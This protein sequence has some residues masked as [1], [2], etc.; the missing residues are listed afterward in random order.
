MWRGPGK[1]KD[2]VKL[3]LAPKL[4]E[5]LVWVP[6]IL[7]CKIFVPSY[8]FDAL[9]CQN[10]LFS[11]P[12]RVTLPITLL[13]WNFCDRYTLQIRSPKRLGHWNLIG[14]KFVKGCFLNV[15][16]LGENAPLIIF[17]MPLLLDLTHKASTFFIFLVF[18][19][20]T[21]AW[22]YLIWLSLTICTSNFYFILFYFIEFY[23]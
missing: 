22:I 6:V 21:L 12:S 19:G 15:L 16:A 10:W 13:D 18:L 1:R 9:L 2:I 14:C 17:R 8:A 7:F 20:H 11:P 23:K 5:K 3:N 4:M